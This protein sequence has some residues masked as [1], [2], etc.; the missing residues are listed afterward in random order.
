MV[1]LDPEK[2]EVT[3]ILQ[4]LNERGKKPKP[5]KVVRKAEAPVKEIIWKGK[6]VNNLRLPSYRKDSGDARIG[7]LCGIAV[8]KELEGERY[9]CSWHRLLVHSEDKKTVRVNPRF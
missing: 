7:W 6:Q 3:D 8:A 1:D 5:W 9:N 4:A 2:S